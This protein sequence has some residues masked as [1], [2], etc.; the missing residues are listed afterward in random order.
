MGTG[1]TNTG[2]FDLTLLGVYSLWF[3]L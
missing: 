1:I 3:T 2:Q